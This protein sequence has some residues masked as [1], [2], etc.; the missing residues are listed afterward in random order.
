MTTD[1]KEIVLTITDLK[2]TY[3]SKVVLDGINFQMEKGERVAIL[4]AN[5]CG[6]TTL[7]EIICQTK[8]YT[9]GKIEYNFKNKDVK[10]AIG[11]QFQ[12][13]NWPSGLSAYDILVF[14]KAIYP[15]V[16]N[17]WVEKLV[18]SFDL[19][20]FYKRSL[21][22][23]SGGQKQRFNALLAVFHNPEFIILDEISNGLDLQLKYNVLKFLKKLLDNNGSSLL[24]VSH[25]PDEVNFLCNRLVIID[26]GKIFLNKTISDINKKYESVVKLMNMY[27]DGKLSENNDEKI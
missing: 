9:S 13:G 22:K 24:I 12:E 17:E 4:G 26:K 2:K 14:Y 7:V 10:Q 3:G 19:T 18:K 20:D 16:T 5:G 11:I 23:L 27:F 6:K 1:K 15:K 25:S 8:K 21:I